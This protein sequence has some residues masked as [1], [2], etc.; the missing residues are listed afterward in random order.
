M[1]QDTTPHEG[2]TCTFGSGKTVWE[3]VKVNRNHDGSIKDLHLSK[4]LGDGYTNRWAQPC[5]IRNLKAQTL[6]VSLATILALREEAEKAAKKVQD[7]IRSKARPGQLMEIVGDTNSTLA[8]Y[9]H[10]YAIHLED[11]EKEVAEAQ[12]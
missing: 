3:I 9:A 4:Y 7:S 11:V 1:A 12:A 6:R 2:M 5:E 10:V 8:N